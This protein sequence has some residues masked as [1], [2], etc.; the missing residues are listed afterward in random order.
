MK[1]SVGGSQCEMQNGKTRFLLTH[2]DVC[3]MSSRK[4]EILLGD[5]ASNWT[6]ECYQIQRDLSSESSPSRLKIR[7]VSI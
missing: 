6:S 4:L 2:L 3:E 1:N 7:K 5:V